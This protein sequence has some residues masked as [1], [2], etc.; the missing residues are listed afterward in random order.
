MLICNLSLM[1]IS[2]AQILTLVKIVTRVP[3]HQKHLKRTT[4]SA[5]QL[6]H[7][8]S[9]ETASNLVPSSLLTRRPYS[10]FVTARSLSDPRSLSDFHN[11][12]APL[13]PEVSLQ[14]QQLSDPSPTIT[15]RDLSHRYST[16]T[17]LS[18]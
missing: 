4:N 17:E 16:R 2:S 8:G 13:R 11:C 7:C 6:D 10:K 12:Q 14:H 15:I 18:N 9:K 3:P 1:C 5:Y